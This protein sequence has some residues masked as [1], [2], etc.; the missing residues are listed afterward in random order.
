MNS[1]FM[2]GAVVTLTDLTP[3]QN[4]N[5]DA[6]VSDRTNFTS[7]VNAVNVSQFRSHY[8]SFVL[9]VHFCFFLVDPS[10]NTACLRQQFLARRNKRLGVF[11]P[12]CLPDGGYDKVQCH[13]S[14]CFCMDEEGEEVPGTRVYRNEN[15]DCRGKLALPTG[16]HS[17]FIS[18]S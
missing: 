9:R 15:L 8:Q 17:R 14:V 12:R 2:A 3:R 4:V 13:G 11:V 1:L 16:N 7:N 6:W 18:Q 10:A 5:F